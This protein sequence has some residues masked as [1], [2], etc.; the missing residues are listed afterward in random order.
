MSA[1]LASEPPLLMAKIRQFPATPATPSF[2]PAT[3]ETLFVNEAA[4][5]AQDVPWPLLR[6]LLLA[7]IFEKSNDR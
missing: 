5:L 7:T 6:E 3:A 2:I 4:A 1:Y